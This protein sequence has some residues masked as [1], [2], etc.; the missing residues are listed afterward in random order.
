MQ[1]IHFPT[2]SLNSIAPML[3]PRHNPGVIVCN[4]RVYVFGGHSS[5]SFQ[6]SCESLCL[7]SRTWQ[8]LPSMPRACSFAFSPCYYRNRI[9]LPAFSGN[10]EIDIFDLKSQQFLLE[11]LP[12]PIRCVDSLAMIVDTE[13]VLL[14]SFGRKVVWSL[15]TGKTRQEYCLKLAKKDAWLGYASIFQIGSVLYWVERDKAACRI[16]EAIAFNRSIDCLIYFQPIGNW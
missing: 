16:S 7:L 9:Y 4:E 14:D 8:A 5:A 6:R 13:L 11:T 2:Y 15:N 10:S 3:V 1:E 12:V